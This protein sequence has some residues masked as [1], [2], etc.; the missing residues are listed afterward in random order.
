M[1]FPLTPIE[2]WLLSKGFVYEENSRDL[3]AI[4]WGCRSGYDF[5]HLEFYRVQSGGDVWEAI[6]GHHASGLNPRVRFGCCATLDEVEAVY[7]L[8]RR[9]NGY[10]GPEPEREPTR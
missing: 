7:D 4:A 3:L 6:I 2:L 8:H 5:A 9:L 10:P 1:T